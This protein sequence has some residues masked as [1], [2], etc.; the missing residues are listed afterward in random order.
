MLEN[1]KQ[2][3][4]TAVDRRNMIANPKKD[5]GSPLQRTLASE[6]ITHIKWLGTGIRGMRSNLKIEDQIM[7]PIRG[8]KKEESNIANCSRKLEE[9]IQALG[10][11]LSL[12]K[13]CEAILIAEEAD[14]K[15]KNLLAGK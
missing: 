6:S 14:L 9:S 11:A 1:V 5:T 10:T 4:A 8:I 2:R 15:E 12:I 3:A 7:K 13:D